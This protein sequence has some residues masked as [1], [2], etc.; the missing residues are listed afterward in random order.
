MPQ[1]L[2]RDVV[3][4]HPDVA[5][6]RRLL[7]FAAV[8]AMGGK[9]L[10]DASVEALAPAVRLRTA[11]FGQPMLDVERLVRFI[12]GE[13]RTQTKEAASMSEHKKLGVFS[14]GDVEWHPPTP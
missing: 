9:H 1:S 3:I 5:L 6:N 8:E 4:V 14:V 10:A 2:L 13:D 11:R 7:R 12:E